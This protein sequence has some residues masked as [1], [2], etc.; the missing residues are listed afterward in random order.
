MVR[1]ILESVPPQK[2]QQDLKK[3]CRRAVELGATDAKII[4]A[5]DV[6]IDERVRAKC[7][8]PKCKRFGTNAHCPPHAMPLDEM[9]RLVSRFEYGILTRLEAPVEDMA[10]AAALQ[11]RSDQKHFRKNYEIVSRLE[12]EAFHQGYYLALA[13]GAG[14]CQGVFCPSLDCQALEPGKG[15]RHPLKARA[16]M[17]GAGMDVFAMATRAGWNIYPIGENT[18]P[19]DVPSAALYGLVLVY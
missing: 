8:F 3:L 5:R 11:K 12:A 9:R 4:A 13:F 14:S 17:E 16:S 2:L 7:T 6:I 10:G 19:A 1:K 18:L 15:C